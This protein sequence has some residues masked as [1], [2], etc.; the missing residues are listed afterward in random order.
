MSL[1]LYNHSANRGDCIQ[2]CRRKYKVT[3]DETG[4][5]LIID[6]HYV[7]SPKDLC[8]I[9]FID[10]LIEAGVK[11]FKI[12]GRARSPDYVY[13]VVKAYREAIDSY[14]SGTYTKEK[15]D[16]WTK[17]LETVFN[18]GFWH[19]GYYLGNKLGEWAG[20][21]G[22]KAA[23]QK[24]FV[25]KIQNYYSKKKIASVYIEAGGISE[26]DELMITGPTTGI[27]KLN[28]DE[29]WIDNKHEKQ[30]GK[31]ALVTIKVPEKVRKNDKV[32]VLK[33]KDKN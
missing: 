26:N 24:L 11:I 15:I 7:M 10:K 5:E 1:A 8:T 6:N 33:D 32:Y 23:K 25:G 9:A 2:P 14:Y 22:S 30:S 18:R 29:I 20:V 21:Y 16:C 4:D 3:D 27:V 31:G 17:E 28:A 13:T 12:E 19:G